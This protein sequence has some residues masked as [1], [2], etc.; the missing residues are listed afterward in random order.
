MFILEAN[1]AKNTQLHRKK[2]QIEVVRN[3]IRTKK[4]M[5][6]YVYLHQEWN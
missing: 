1:T 6:A 5:S 3:W 4:S 2:L